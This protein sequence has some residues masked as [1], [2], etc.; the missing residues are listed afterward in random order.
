MGNATLKKH[1]YR[2]A[3]SRKKRKVLNRNLFNLRELGVLA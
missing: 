3:Q 2:F 1:Y